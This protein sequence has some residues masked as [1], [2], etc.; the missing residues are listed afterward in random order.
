LENGNLPVKRRVGIIMLLN[1]WELFELLNVI[2][3]VSIQLE[4]ICRERRIT[5]Q[6]RLP[7]V[8]FSRKKREVDIDIDDLKN[9]LDELERSQ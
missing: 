8:K 4:G 5:G 3:N 6:N 2:E 9:L 1:D 7:Y